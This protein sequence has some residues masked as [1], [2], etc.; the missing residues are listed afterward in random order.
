MKLTIINSDKTVYI[1]YKPYVQLSLTNVPKVVHALQWKDTEGHI[2]YNNGM[3][4]EIIKDLPNWAIEAKLEW[5]DKDAK[6]NE[7]IQQDYANQ[8][9]LNTPKDLTDLEKLQ[10]IRVERNNRLFASDWTQLQ[11]S[12]VNKE[13]WAEYRQALRDL[14]NNV[15]VNNPVYP[16]IPNA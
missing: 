13:T 11:D 9:K 8:L 16:T 12:K 7:L 3:P 10:I 1:D 14:P 5:E 4:N 15:D 6:Y 2:E